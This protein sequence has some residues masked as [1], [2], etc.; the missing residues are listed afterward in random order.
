VVFGFGVLDCCAEVRGPVRWDLR[1]LLMGG[2]T[3]VWLGAIE[4]KDGAGMEV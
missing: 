2:R 4:V 1:V 3:K